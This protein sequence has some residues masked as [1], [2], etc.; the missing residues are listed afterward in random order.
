[1]IN[2]KACKKCIDALSKEQKEL[3]RQEMLRRLDIMEKT[4]KEI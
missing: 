4:F 3:L 2:K 1:M